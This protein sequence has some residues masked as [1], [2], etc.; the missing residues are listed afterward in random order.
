M[1]FVNLSSF[2]IRLKTNFEE[3]GAVCR[4]TGNKLYRCIVT[5]RCRGTRKL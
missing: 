3:F 1:Y 4:S 5:K 2:G